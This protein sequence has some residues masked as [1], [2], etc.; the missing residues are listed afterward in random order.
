MSA[1]NNKQMK[2][3]KKAKHFLFEDA[4]ETWICTKDPNNTTQSCKNKLL[5]KNTEGPI[6]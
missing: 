5:V 4:D 6:L 1:P 2:K 3:E